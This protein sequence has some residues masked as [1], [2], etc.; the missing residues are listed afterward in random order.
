MNRLPSIVRGKTWIS[1]FIPRAAYR[2]SL[3]SRKRFRGFSYHC[4][5]DNSIQSTRILNAYI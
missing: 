2:L 1:H 4:V 5:V 3:E